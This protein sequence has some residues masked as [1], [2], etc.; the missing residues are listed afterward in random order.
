MGKAHY[1]WGIETLQYS[2]RRECNDSPAEGTHLDSI[3]ALNTWLSIGQCVLG[4][5]VGHLTLNRILEI[6]VPK[7]L[8]GFSVSGIEGFNPEF[9][10]RDVLGRTKGGNN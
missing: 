2:H 8:F 6:I 3:I 5:G 1:R 7:E 4:L 10:R 9:I